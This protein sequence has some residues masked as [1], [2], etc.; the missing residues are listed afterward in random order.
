[1]RVVRRKA[2][3]DDTQD[4]WLKRLRAQ[5]MAGFLVVVPVGASILIL[6]WVFT[7]IDNIL[8][9]VVR[10]I[11]G[12]NIPGV[13]FGVTVVLIY[14]IGLITR[15]VIGNRVIKYGDSIMTRVPLFRG[16]YLGI[17]Q[18]LESFS[19]PT[20]TGFMQVVLVEFPR[21]GIRAIAFVTNEITD[22]NGKKQLSVL[23]P[24]SPNP[25]SGFLQIVGEEDIVRTKISVENALKMIVSAG[26]LTPLEVQAKLSSTIAKQ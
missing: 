16:L 12:H 23:I 25:T 20:K 3:M 14:I 7:T 11:A 15:N 6:I 1:M 17:R 22:A 21:K 2:K 4:G 24:T 18:I 8:Q 13:G 10:A 5:F 19:A 26:R 9:P